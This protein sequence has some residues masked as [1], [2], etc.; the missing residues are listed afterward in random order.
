MGVSC[1]AA[2]AQDALKHAP[3]G[4]ILVAFDARMNEIYLG[5][6]E[7]D[8]VSGLV[9]PVIKDCLVSPDRLPVMPEGITVAV[10]AAG[11]HQQ[12]LEAALGDLVWSVDDAP[13]ASAVARL[14]AADYRGGAAVSAAQAQPL[15]LRNQV[16]QGAVR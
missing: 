16:T 11:P 10:G 1:L 4:K 14:A 5:I 9:R 3:K 2:C 12:I 13:R 8:E 6:Y 7:Q 15:Y